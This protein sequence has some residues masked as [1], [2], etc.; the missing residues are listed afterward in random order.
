MELVSKVFIS[1]IFPLLF[2]ENI[3]SFYQASNLINGFVF[4]SA[5][6]FIALL[7]FL[8]YGGR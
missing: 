3:C 2:G 8:I 5:V 4:V 1:G 6:S 7:G